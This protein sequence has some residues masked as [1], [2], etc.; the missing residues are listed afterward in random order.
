MNNKYKPS[1]HPKIPVTDQIRAIHFKDLIQEAW[2]IFFQASIQSEPRNKTQKQ[3]TQKYLD[4]FR[5]SEHN[6]H[7]YDPTQS[8]TG[9]KMAQKRLDELIKMY[10]V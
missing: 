3:L 9:R 10:G 7:I 1:Y 5:P 2:M 4:E 8:L 6:G